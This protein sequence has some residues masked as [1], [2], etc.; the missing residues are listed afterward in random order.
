MHGTP[1]LRLFNQTAQIRSPIETRC[2]S[3]Y[4]G[5]A[6]IVPVAAAL[7]DTSARTCMAARS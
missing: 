1:V 5:A 7:L 2:E 6:D 3:Q 4:E